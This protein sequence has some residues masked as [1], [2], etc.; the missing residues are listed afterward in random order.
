MIKPR[1][2]YGISRI[3]QVEKKNHGWYVRVTLKGVTSQKFFSDKVHGNKNKSLTAA[4][5]HRDSLV[6]ALPE[7]RQISASK[8]RASNK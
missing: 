8:K 7:S 2:N 4:K 1:P 3:D 6:A 5:E